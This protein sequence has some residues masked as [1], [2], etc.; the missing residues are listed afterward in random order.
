MDIGI[1]EDDQIMGSSLIQRFKLEG[2][3]VHWWKTGSDAVNSLEFFEKDII[4][5]DIR[6]PDITGE[7]V[8]RQ[9]SRDGLA[10]PFLFITG[11]GEIDQAVRLMRL[12]ACDYITKPFEFDEFL[13]R[14]ERNARGS[15]DLKGKSYVLGVSAEMRELQ[16]S[17]LK[18]GQT[19]FPVLITGETG[20]GKESAARFLHAHSSSSGHP[21]MSVNCA[22][23]PGELLEKEIFGTEG[24][25][26][27]NA[28]SLHRG[29]AERVGAGTL[30][31][32]DVSRIPLSV[33]ARLMELLGEKSFTRAG[34]TTAIA[35]HGRIVVSDSSDLESAISKGALREDLVF[36][37]SVLSTSISPLRSR[38]ED[39]EW[40]LPQ[41]I[42]A[43][44]SRQGQLLKVLSA[45]AEEVALD[46][47]WS[48]NALEMRNRVERAVALSR[49]QELTVADLFPDAD[50]GNYGEQ[51]FPSL[52]HARELA[53]KR[54][55]TRALER[56]AGQI[57]EAAKL[58]R[59]SRTT[60]W[61]KMSRLDLG[62]KERSKT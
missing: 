53:E 26:E 5:C 54:Q 21:F 7:T 38:P 52:A 27:N 60:L 28:P 59:V 20:V 39:I 44:C 36:K 2:H 17:L 25:S 40:L 24:A 10:P 16:K 55:I 49:D 48:G 45:Q 56:S 50:V 47:G 12:G 61:E 29:Y 11:Y 4:I 62:S 19:D 13:V 14:V 22:A 51:A 34:G 23:I 42:G 35:F 57:G 30:H 8:M 46:H 32:R 41:M 18:F 15:D 6:L 3:N 9:A 33:Q 1:V 58:L 43:A 31:I 37:L